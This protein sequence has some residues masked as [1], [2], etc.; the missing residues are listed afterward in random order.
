MV[1]GFG[2]LALRV[3]LWVA[4][5]EREAEREAYWRAVSAS[6]EKSRDCMLEDGLKHEVLLDRR[7]GF[8][9]SYV[10]VMRGC[11]E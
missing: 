11:D 7:R 6:N 8:I 9:R 4:P 1:F 2:D 5:R 10:H 3:R